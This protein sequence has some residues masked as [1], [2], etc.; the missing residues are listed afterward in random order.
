M[1]EKPYYLYLQK[2]KRFECFIP[3][4]VTTV[5]QWLSREWGDT[6]KH[7]LHTHRHWLMMRRVNSCYKLSWMQLSNLPCKVLVFVY[8]RCRHYQYRIEQ[9][10]QLLCQQ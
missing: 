1:K 10:Y 3:F 8:T 9:F 5:R 4:R 7:W 6:L 2:L